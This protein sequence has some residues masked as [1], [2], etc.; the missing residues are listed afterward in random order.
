[1]EARD[2]RKTQHWN[3]NESRIYIALIKYLCL[4]AF[5]WVQ[6][7]L[8]FLF[9]N[10]INVSQFQSLASDGGALFSA[11]GKS[12]GM[13]QIQFNFMQH[14]SRIQ[15]VIKEGLCWRSLFIYIYSK[16]LAENFIKEGTL[17]LTYSIPERKSGYRISLPCYAMH[18]WP[19]ISLLVL[20][21]WPYQ[22]SQPNI[23]ICCLLD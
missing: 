17:F 15:I 9:E 23:S 12:Y 8:I 1:M 13:N 16:R 18:F 10:V 21:Q 7:I 14:D 3:R 22:A 4:E 5:V 6:V 20:S 2:K 19:V 11:W